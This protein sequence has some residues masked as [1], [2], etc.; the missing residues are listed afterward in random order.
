MTSTVNG[1]VDPGFEAVRDSF[2]RAFDGRPRMGAALAVYVNGA[3]VVDLWGG[4]ADERSGE[5]WQGDTASVVF[6]CGKGLMSILIARLVED[7]R[8]SYDAAVTD[9]WPE[10]GAAGKSSVTVAELVS[11]QAGLSAPSTDW[12]LD[13]VLDWTRATRLLAAQAP[14]WTPGRG[15]AYHALTHGWLVGELVRRT[16]G[17]SPGQYFAEVVAGP[18]HASAWIGLPPDCDAPIAHLQVAP[19][20]AAFWEADALRDRGDTPNW[21]WRAMTLGSRPPAGIGHFRRRLQ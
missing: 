4:V 11:H 17:L 10:F 18:L 3:P 5:I 7:G 21:G 9:Y 12:T 8:L 20:L 1:R 16:T 2:D 14:L 19:A 15:Y 6:S 13:D